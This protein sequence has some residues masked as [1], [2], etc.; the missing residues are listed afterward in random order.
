MI[1]EK[2]YFTK[3]IDS[4]ISSRLLPEG[5]YLN[6]MNARTGVTQ[7]G[8]SGE[9]QNIPGTLAISQSVFPPYG[10]STNIGSCFD[11]QNN[12]I[13]YFQHNTFNYHGIYAYDISSGITYAVVYD[14]QVTG[15]LNFSKSS[16]IHSCNVVNGMLSWVD[17]TNNQPRSIQLDA[18]IKANKSTYVTDAIPYQFPL[19]FSEITLIKPPPIFTPNINKFNDSGFVNNFIATE[20]FQ[21]AYMYEFYNVMGETVVGAYSQ[22]SRLNKPT[23][24]FNYIQVKMD[25]RE[26]I[27]LSV[28][29]VHL[30]V[31]LGA[32]ID[33]NRTGSTAPSIKIIKTWDREVSADAAEINAQ[34]AVTAQLTY[35][36]YNNITGI[37]L[38]QYLILKQA[39]LVPYYAQTQE[40]AK[41]RLFLGN[42]VSGDP[43][44][45]TT[46]LSFSLLTTN[47]TPST[48]LKN[49]YDIRHRN[50]R[51]GGEAYAY[52]GWFVYLTEVSPVGWYAITS[53]E[54]LNTV[55][56]T[57]PAQ[58]PAPSN[59]AFGGLAF[60]GSNLTEVV[61]ATAKPGTFRWD[62]PF[63]T[64]YP[65]IV[66][67]TGVSVQTWDVFKNAGQRKLG[68]QFFDFAMRPVG[69]V[70]TNDDL[71]AAIPR[72]NF[73]YGTGVTGLVWTLSNASAQAEIPDNA[74]YYAVVCTKELSTRYFIESFTD[75]VKYVSRGTSGEYVYSNTTFITGAVGIGIDTTALIKSGL[76]Y[77]QQEN[78]VAVLIQDTGSVY[79]LPVIAVDGNFI[80]VKAQ[81][82]GDVS[83][84]RFIYEIYTPYQTSEQEPFFIMG[85]VYKV[86]DPT[87]STR[88]YEILSDTLSPDCYAVT[89]NYNNTTYLAEAMSPN[90]LYYQ[91]WDTDCG[92]VTKVTK[93]ARQVKP[94]EGVFSNVYIPGTQTNG[95]NSFEALNFFNT[96]KEG[97]AISRFF[98]TDKIEDQGSVMLAICRNNIN[99]I[100]LGETQ[101]ADSSGATRFFAQS[102]GVIGTINNLQVSYGT[103]NPESIVGYRGLVFGFDKNNGV[104]W[105][106]SANG[107]DAI[108]DYGMTRFFKRYA[109]DYLNSSTGNLDNINGYHWVRFSIDPFHRELIV[110][111]P[112]LIYENY[113]TTLP[114][115][116]TVPKYATSIINR[117]DVYDKLQKVMCY[118]FDENKW[119]S[120]FEY[121]AEWFQDAGDNMYGWKFGTMYQHNADTDNWNNF[122]GATRPIR[123]CFA[124][125]LNA[126]LLKILNNIAIEGNVA[127]DFTVAYVDYPNVQI[128]DLTVDDFT[129]QEGNFYAT[130]FADRLSPNASGTAD[131][132]MMNGDSLT[133]IVIYI[134]L[135]IQAYEE[136][137]FI[138]FV[139]VGMSA[140]RGQK[141]ILNQ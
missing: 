3:G 130:F 70:V 20:S 61:L 91:R 14:T 127:P 4:D 5:R 76:G 41:N 1:I 83:K 125:N 65:N 140:S 135:E 40:V 88:N 133:A 139:D 96:P 103:E 104:V 67:I 131:E 90:D 28:R 99:S 64:L 82:I 59:V 94:F 121:G 134:M 24:N 56:G 85:E 27:P 58:S 102:S 115:Y 108:S 124:A 33:T 32:D 31:R 54:H 72:R 26:F 49:L 50:G 117:F 79:V 69:G 111:L 68:I 109:Q 105:Q 34:N 95:L 53:T 37:T 51:G 16:L 11:Q 29:Y 92:K 107:L 43:T 21:F 19:N 36:F 2:K 80:I 42:T 12:R 120:N 13:I 57:Y 97:G 129:D 123:L 45:D 84:A 101:V 77:S 23:D 112:G 141:Q 55:N 119:S 110:S 138:N 6:L 8:R 66:T 73:T 9:V 17:G 86:L 63:V 128:S 87:L 15:G 81:D 60:R 48:L 106:Y 75:A 118:K 122:Y 22:S 126:S 44:P 137:N 30:I 114:S 78:D 38:A 98:V 62:G 89:R 7:Y 52:V 35:N 74:Y 132:K 113:A 116:T 100:Y 10:I 18:A 47:L 46:S 25:G 93:S 136:L 39:D 71:I